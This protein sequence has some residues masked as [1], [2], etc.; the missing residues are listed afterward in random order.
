MRVWTA[1]SQKGGAA[2]S[3]MTL[4]LAVV[5]S[6]AGERTL[7]I[8]CDEQRSATD[9]WES[10][11]GDPER[12]FLIRA[13]TGAVRTDV[14]RAREAGFTHVLIDTPGF[15]GVRASEAASVATLAV[16]PCQPS[17]SD[18]RSTLQTARMLADNEIPFVIVLTRCP[19]TGREQ[20]EAADAFR[21]IGPVCEQA[22]HERKAH[23]RAYAMG[24]GITEYAAIEP[25]AQPAA[26]EMRAIYAALRAKED[27]LR[28]GGAFGRARVAP[29]PA[30]APPESALAGDAGAL[31]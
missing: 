30:T 9:W 27:R 14:E 20:R 29:V 13:E 22:C 6:E 11:E 8:D 10:R 21:T 24:L 1:V 7:V 31:A 23:K 5:A 18:M 15:A 17:V 25:S 26:E 12:P 16:V 19:S 3:T 2:K 4:S 28:G